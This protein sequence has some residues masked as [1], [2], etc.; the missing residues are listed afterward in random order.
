EFVFEAKSPGRSDLARIGLW[1]YF[2]FQFL[3]ADQRMIEKITAA[4]MEPVGWQN[5]DSL[6]V[7]LYRDW[8]QNAHVPPQPARCLAARLPQKL[9]KGQT[10]SIQNR[11]LQI[12]QLHKGVVDSHAIQ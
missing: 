4:Q 7:R 2:E 9:H 10:A 1:S 11:K 6:A 12:V 8:L 5:R 3:F